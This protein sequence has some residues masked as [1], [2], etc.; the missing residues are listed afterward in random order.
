MT[1]TAVLVVVSIGMFACGLLG[2]MIRRNF[3]VAFMCV[4]LML[5]AVNLLL[6]TLAKVNESLT[7]H[8]GVALVMVI[9]A[10]ETAVGLAIVLAFFRANKSVDVHQAVQLRG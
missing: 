8:V 9:A 3:L 2:V 4:E 7:G 1:E 6:V 5:N 10:C